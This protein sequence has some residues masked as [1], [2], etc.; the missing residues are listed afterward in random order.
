MEKERLTW[1]EVVEKYPN[2][3]VALSDYDMT[4]INNVSG[5]VEAVCRDT[6]IGR[7]DIEIR[8]RGI[9]KLYWSRTTGLPG[10][11]LWM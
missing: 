1:K 3:W 8:N 10:G 7:K 6:E 4:D 11:A 9:K 5:I 2:R